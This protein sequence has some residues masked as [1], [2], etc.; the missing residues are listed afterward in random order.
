MTTPAPV[1]LT[2]I[3]QVLLTAAETNA[4]GG[5]VTPAD[6]LTWSVDNTSVLTL[7]PGTGGLTCMAV[8]A[9]A[10]T[11]NV[12][13]TDPGASLTSAPLQVDVTMAAATAVTISAG[14]PEDQVPA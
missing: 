10:G 5:A 6:T 1:A 9:A 3:Q 11:A 13:V 8:A 14:A 12:T 4:E 7:Q 2:T